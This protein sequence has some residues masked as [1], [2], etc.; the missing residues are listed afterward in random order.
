MKIYTKTGDRGNTSLFS[1]ERVSK[2]ARRVEAY[3]DIDE[4]N[5][6]MGLLTTTFSPEH[7]ESL[8]E[9]RRIQSDLLCVGAWLATVPGSPSA[10]ALPE[11]DESHSEWLEG[12]MDRMQEDL[13]P[14]KGFLLPGGHAAAAWAHVARTICR[15]AERRVVALMESD[16]AGGTPDDFR[17]VITY[18]NRLSDYLFVLARHLN[19]IHEISDIL[20]G[21]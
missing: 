2:A 20:W 14:L 8:G 4:L 12:A 17:P 11:L 13:S 18:L 7:S 10:K 5:S 9:I 19:R 3:G 21:P 1:G 6:V 16:E 15:R